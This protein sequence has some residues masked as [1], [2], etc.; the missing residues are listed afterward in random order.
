MEKT[1][2]PMVVSKRVDIVKEIRSE[3]L[4]L[5]G[6]GVSPEQIIVR[7]ENLKELRKAYL[8]ET[9]TKNRGFNWRKLSVTITFYNL[10]G[11]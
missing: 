10:A 1:L 8:G 5:Q 6:N 2:K 11:I 7:G 4:E 9:M 3:M